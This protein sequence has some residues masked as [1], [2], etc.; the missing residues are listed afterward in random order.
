[1]AKLEEAA[2]AG[3]KEVEV[4]IHGGLRL[5]MLTLI[6]EC[7]VKCLATGTAG[8]RR[9]WA[10]PDLAAYCMGIRSQRCALVVGNSVLSALNV[11]PRR[12]FEVSC[13]EAIL[14]ALSCEEL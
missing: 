14:Q 5:R 11:D 1:M 3:K 7:R 6:D 2:V 12:T 8:S 9:P 10:K 4:Q 13:A